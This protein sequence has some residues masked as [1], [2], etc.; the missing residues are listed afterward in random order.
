MMIRSDET[1]IRGHWKWVG[2]KVE[3]DA[4]SRR[5]DALVRDYLR[6]CGADE[7][8]W[9]TLYVDPNDGRFWELTYPQPDTHGGGPPMLR[10]LSDDAAKEKYGGVA[11]R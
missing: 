2:F 9:T 3:E 1:E 4:N 8:G 11:A 7:T 5:I 6:L 10:W